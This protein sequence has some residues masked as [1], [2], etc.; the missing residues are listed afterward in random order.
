MDE[1]ATRPT[2][3]QDLEDQLGAR[4]EEFHGW[5]TPLLY[6]SISTEALAV[7]S[8]AGLFDVSHMGRLFVKA[9]ELERLGKLFTNNVE[10]T[11][12]GKMKYSYSLDE[13]G[14]IIDDV[15]SYGLEDGVL[16]VVNATAFQRD[17]EW[18][19][20]HGVHPIN[21]TD[22]TA[23]I[24]VQGPASL[25]IASELGFQLGGWFTFNPLSGWEK[26]YEGGIASR[27]GYTGED[28][29]EV[30]GTTDF[31]RSIFQKVI[32][33]GAKP[34]G[35][36]ARDV[37]RL[38]AGYT[39]SGVD[40][41]GMTP[42]DLGGSRFVKW[43][44]DFIGK[45]ALA[46]KKEK[47]GERQPF[48]L[49]AGN[50]PR[51][52]YRCAEAFVSSG[53]FSPTLKKG[54]GLAIPSSPKERPTPGTKLTLFEEGDPNKKTIE[55]EVTELPFVPWRYPRRSFPQITRFSSA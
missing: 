25:S 40:T 36:G 1:A 35:L 16:L 30:I 51:R 11:K 46:V 2:P 47:E 28:G 24:A 14:M 20:S 17:L 37:L 29:F 54:I 33:I 39:L 32:R 34:A 41:V 4:F 50:I 45:G 26:A 48:G 23:M 10:S 53:T 12:L 52:G 22:E 6:T 31:V 13:Y 5:S 3:L 55:A 18:M 43:E 15:V 44:K 49:I 27:S 19:K 9:D 38:E 8:G 42:L 7:R 21:V